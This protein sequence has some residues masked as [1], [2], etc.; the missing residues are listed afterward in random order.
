MGKVVMF[1]HFS[2]S[3]S[4]VYSLPNS[5]D[6]NGGVSF[7]KLFSLVE[8][9]SAVVISIGFYESYR[10]FEEFFVF[11]HICVSWIFPA[12]ANK[13]Q[14]K[15]ANTGNQ[16]KVVLLGDS[17]VGKSSI[18]LRFITEQFKEEQESTIG[19]SFLSKTI[20]IENK[21]VSFQIWDTAG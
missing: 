17:G 15:M 9:M 14:T 13:F 16:V 18:V 1:Q 6:F 19:A 21:P 3:Y 5:M 20:Q 12:S 4:V 10:S 2:G 8:E 7:E 11:A